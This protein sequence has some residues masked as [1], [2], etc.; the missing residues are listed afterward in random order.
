MHALDRFFF[1]LLIVINTSF[2][3]QRWKGINTLLDC[4]VK[5]STVLVTIYC[6]LHNQVSTCM[7]LMSDKISSEGD[8]GF[9]DGKGSS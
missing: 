3:C 1:I 8:P 4:I 2:L 6:H 9:I 5:Y 7:N